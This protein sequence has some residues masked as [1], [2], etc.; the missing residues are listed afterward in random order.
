MKAPSIIYSDV[1]S[2]LE[3]IFICHNNLKKSSTTKINKHT[4]SG[5]SLYTHCSFDAAKNKLDDCRGQDC[6]KK[7]CRDL[8]EH[9]TKIINFE[10]KKM[11]PLTNEENE[12]YL[13]KDVCHISKK[14]FIFDIDSCSEG[15]YI[16]YHRVK[17]H[18]HYTGKYRGAADNIC[19]LRYKTAK[20]IPIGFRN[21]STYDYHF[22][23]KKLVKEF[24]GLFECLGENTEK[25]I[26]FSV[27]IKKQ[28]E[29]DKR[30]TYKLKFID[31][32]RFMA[33]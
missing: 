9:P 5:Y 30:V 11:M 23:T 1:E 12:S 2:L 15:M 10:K 16:K 25:Y 14:E 28:L 27:A 7:F 22:S 18:C 20:E 3:K 32:F 19:N 24:D 17:D 6:M 4:A 8:K 33:T 29:N 31:S 13:K 21:G 26:T